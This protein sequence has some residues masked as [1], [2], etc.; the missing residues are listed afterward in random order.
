[1]CIAAYVGLVTWC[2]THCC[3]FQLSDS[4]PKPYPNEQAARAANA[5]KKCLGK[6]VVLRILLYT[7][8]LCFKPFYKDV[9][10]CCEEYSFLVIFHHILGAYPPDLSLIT[11]ARHGG[12]VEFTHLFPS[13]FCGVTF[14]VY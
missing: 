2:K 8:Y 3:I 14:L 12:E 5:G 9:Y 6:C 4:F 10:L 11:S 1:M 13:S 7:H